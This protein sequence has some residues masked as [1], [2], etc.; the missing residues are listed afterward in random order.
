MVNNPARTKHPLTTE[1]LCELLKLP[2]DKYE[3]VR[4]ALYLKNDEGF[5]IRV[6]DDNGNII[7][8][9]INTLSDDVCLKRFYKDYLPLA[10]KYR[11]R[12]LQHGT[13]LVQLLKAEK[14]RYKDDIIKNDYQTT[15]SNLKYLLERAPE[16][17]NNEIVDATLLNR[18]QFERFR[19]YLLKIRSLGDNQPYTFEKIRAAK[20]SD[21]DFQ[22]FHDN[23]MPKLPRLFPNKDAVKKHFDI[24]ISDYVNLSPKQLDMIIDA[25]EYFSPNYKKLNG[26]NDNIS[27]N[28]DIADA[29][30]LGISQLEPEKNE[31]N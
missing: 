16:F 3:Q 14:T 23:V 10:K 13:Y 24:A 8:D 21:L 17:R 18:Q 9:V 27:V 7:Y 11:D 31:I 2:K 4:D 30:C 29:I 6:D 19:N 12:G 22:N 25:V 15:L 5:E 1:H 26:I 28:D 20:L